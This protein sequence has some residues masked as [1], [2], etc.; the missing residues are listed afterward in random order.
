MPLLA[1]SASPGRWDNR[2]SQMTYQEP[3]W[4]QGPAHLSLTAPTPLPAHVPGELQLWVRGQAF[5][6]P[7]SVAPRGH[8]SIKGVGSRPGAGRAGVRAHEDPRARGVVP[9]GLSCPSRRLQRAW[10]PLSLVGRAGTGWPPQAGLNGHPPPS[11]CP[12]S[13]ELPFPSREIKCF[14]LS[15][16]TAAPSA[17]LR[18]LQADCEWGFRPGSQAGG[19]GPGQAP[20]LSPHEGGSPKGVGA[21]PRAQRSPHWDKPWPGGQA[22]QR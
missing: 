21:A 11:T 22:P 10:L 1:A 3:A 19:G 4:G 16:L 14:F 6:A 9:K 7:V 13:Q 12:P 2:Q 5:P 18:K 17:G 20:F 15:A 8:S